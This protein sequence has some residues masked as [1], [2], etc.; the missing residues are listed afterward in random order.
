MQNIYIEVIPSFINNSEFF[1]KCL[2]LDY[3]TFLNE[4]CH[5]SVYK[6]FY[7]FY[8]VFFAFIKAKHYCR[9]F[10]KNFAN[11]DHKLFK[12]FLDSRLVPLIKNFST[13]SKHLDICWPILLLFATLDTSTCAHRVCCRGKYAIV[14]LKEEV[15]AW[16]T[17]SS[18]GI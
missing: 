12:V 4:K 1:M 2:K 17:Q 14:D 3:L 9:N 5:N 13:V 10:K 18:L 15:K 8:K 16:N 7:R 6:V 11:T